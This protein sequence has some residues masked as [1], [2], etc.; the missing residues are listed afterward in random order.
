MVIVL[1]MFK[2]FLQDE[3]CRGC[4]L[5]PGITEAFENLHLN[6]VVIAFHLNEQKEI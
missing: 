1:V 6:N 5:E 4:L 3:A 2:I